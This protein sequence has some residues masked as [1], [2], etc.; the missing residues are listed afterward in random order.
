MS[1]G[2]GRSSL[3]K[4]PLVISHAG[5][6]GHAPENTLAGIVRALALGAEAVEVDVRA[7]ADGVPV[8]MHDETLDRTTDG[9]GPL[10]SYPLA[11]LRRLDAGSDERVPTLAEAVAQLAGRALLVAEI[12]EGGIEQQV[13]AA[14]A[15]LGQEEAQVWS[16]LPDVLASYRRI[17]PHRRTVLLAEA[18]SMARWP[19]PLQLA[20][21]VGAAGL[22]VRHEWVT[23]EV[24]AQ[25][26]EAGLSLYAWTADEPADL[27]RL[28]LL[29][30]DGIVSNYPERALLLRRQALGH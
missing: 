4:G 17:A 21:E 6:A 3:P 28:L 30:L 20:R 13:E 14:L 16:F 15:P 10:R 26:R 19:V 23:A 7:T 18:R 8:L 5:C 9:H 29:G 27:R 24:A 2:E 12:K 25:V 11:R 22:S 1:D